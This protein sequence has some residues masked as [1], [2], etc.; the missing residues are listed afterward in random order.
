MHDDQL[1]ELNRRLVEINRAAEDVKAA[2]KALE[3]ARSD[4]HE[5]LTELGRTRA[6]TGEQP[7]SIA[8]ARHLYWDF[9]L[10]HVEAIGLAIGVPTS[11]VYEV[12]GRQQDLT[13]TSCGKTFTPEGR[14]SRTNPNHRQSPY[15]RCPTCDRSWSRQQDT[16]HAEFMRRIA[17]QQQEQAARIRQGDYWINVDGEVILPDRPWSYCGGCGSGLNRVPDSEA[18]ATGQGV[19]YRC[20]KCDAPATYT[21]NLVTYIPPSRTS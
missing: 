1:A 8:L 14:T 2:K 7:L 13:C 17:E 9:P 5:Y 12:V 10:I 19:V 20:M 11:M 3:S 4:V 18:W 21:L 15:T 16:E 6:A